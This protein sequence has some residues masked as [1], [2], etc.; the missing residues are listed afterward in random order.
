M[1][2]RPAAELTVGVG[3]TTLTLPQFL[4]TVANHLERPADETSAELL[5]LAEQFLTAGLTAL[6]TQ[7]QPRAWLEYR[8]VTAPTGVPAEL[9]AELLHRAGELLADA[10]ADNF[11]FV[12]KT[13]GLRVRFATATALRSQ[14]EDRL[15]ATWRKCREA[16]LIAEVRHAVYEPEQQLF[17]GPA[18]M[19][20]VHRLFTADS[21]LW[22]DHLARPTR[23]IPSWALSLAAI[24]VLLDHMHITEF[25]DR[26]VWDT[27]RRR[28]GRRFETGSPANWP[29]VSGRMNLLW[30]APHQVSALREP[31]VQPAFSQF[32]RSVADTCDSWR[33]EYFGR[34]DARTGP[35]EAAA[36][37]IVFHWNRA[38]MPK[39]WQVAV[40]EAL[41]DGPPDQG[42][43]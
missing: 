41:A 4:R 6:D 9:Y 35:R 28:F 32:A 40:A 34:Q 43:P 19:D 25:E 1:G 5:P 13:P 2:H 39:N 33:E 24:R 29:E 18:A 21:L 10:S 3:A 20:G 11:Y 37:L 14:V 42:A 31:T 22:L 16:D 23:P 27:V 15:A 36:A 30:Q 12:H 8:L 26:G 17:G 38:R 7:A